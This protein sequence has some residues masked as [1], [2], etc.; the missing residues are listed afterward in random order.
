MKVLVT[1]GG[2]FLGQAICARLIERGHEVLS[3]NRGTY[4]ALAARGVRQIQGDL[5]D[6]DSLADACV[7]IDAVFHVGAKAGAWGS[8]QEYF[9][10]NA[11]PITCWQRV[12]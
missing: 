5:A 8:F 7:G 3:Y 9:D 10:A 11:A 4:P 6:F 2:G 1:G 12:A